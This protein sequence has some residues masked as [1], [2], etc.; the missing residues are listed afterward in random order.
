MRKLS[1]FSFLTQ[2]TFI[3]ISISK[4]CVS[5]MNISISNAIHQSAIKN[6]KIV[7]SFSVFQKSRSIGMSAPVPFG[8]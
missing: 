5:I 2:L 7:S 8:L 3:D 4:I 6:E 1:R